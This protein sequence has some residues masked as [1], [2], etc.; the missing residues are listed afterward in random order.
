MRIFA[1][2][3]DTERLKR[4]FLYEGEREVL[5]VRYHWFRF[6]LGTLM[7]VIF[8]ILIIAV[9]TGVWFAGLTGWIAILAGILVWFVAVFPSL[10]RSFIDWRYDFAFVTTD[11]VVLVD[12]SSLF[13][14]RITPINMEN[15]ASVSTETQFWN[16]LPFGTL[17][18]HLKSGIG[19]DLFLTYIG[20]ADHVAAQIAN[21]VTEYQRR[22][23]LRRYGDTSLASDGV[24]ESEHNAA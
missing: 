9:V 20:R 17:R 6:F 19:Q 15:F 18:F 3:T 14:Q 12:Q 22:K 1:L 4:D 24:G 11:K 5:M 10:L 2:E 16:L 23:D 7:P 21:T 13:R 8:T